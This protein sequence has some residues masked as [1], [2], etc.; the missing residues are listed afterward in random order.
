MTIVAALPK[1]AA[2]EA[3]VRPDKPAAVQGAVRL[4]KLAAGALAR[5]QLRI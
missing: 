5:T 2:P 4:D 1:L 3:A